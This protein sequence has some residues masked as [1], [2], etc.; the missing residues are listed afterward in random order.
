ME[1]VEIDANVKIEVPWEDD[2]LCD[3]IVANNFHDVKVKSEPVDNSVDD[4]ENQDPKHEII[5][6]KDEFGQ[7][8]KDFDLSNARP[9]SDSSESDALLTGNLFKKKEKNPNS[10]NCS[11]EIID[12]KD[13]FGHA[14]KDF[15]LSK[16]NLSSDC[17]ENDALATE[18]L[19]KEEEKSRNFII[20]SIC[21]ENFEN[22]KSWKLHKKMIH[23]KK[24]KYLCSF[25]PAKFSQKCQLKIHIKNSRLKGHE[26][27]LKHQCP[28]CPAMFEQKIGVKM[29]IETVHEKKKEH[30][31]PVKFSQKGHKGH[32]GNKLFKC[33][34][35]DYRSSRKNDLKRHISSVHGLANKLYRCNIC[36]YSCS[37]KKNMNRHVA[38]VHEGK[39][40]FKCKVC[41][42]SCS[43]K[44]NLNKHVASVHV[45][46]KAFTCKT[47]DYKSSRKTDMNRHIASV[48]EGKKQF[49][50]E[51]CDYRSARKVDLKK[52]I[53]SVH[54]NTPFKDTGTEPF[55]CTICD[56][57]FLR[58]TNMAIFMTK[59]GLSYHIAAAH[60][61]NIPINKKY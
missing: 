50:C 49:K 6:T 46:N 29:H 8:L 19:T 60:E 9:T 24:K 58:K 12:I 51:A 4:G 11:H 26:V 55:V 1:T 22:K 25:C 38:S 47:C 54:E 28:F 48:H 36:E 20:C 39:K 13:E 41:N 27:K 30:Q 44:G 34:V 3:K 32:E 10:I 42:F 35:C 43:E 33:E 53:S 15:D 17:L 23:Q 40:P 37:E 57:F 16:S 31:C 45:G 59:G 5:D 18:N 21:Y 52:H 56:A 14:M 7:A 2:V 61:R